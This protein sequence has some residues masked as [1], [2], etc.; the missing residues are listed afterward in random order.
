VVVS[1]RNFRSKLRAFG[2]KSIF[3]QYWCRQAKVGLSGLSAQRFEN[4]KREVRQIEA[5]KLKDPNNLLIPTKQI[6][7]VIRDFIKR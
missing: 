7:L 3:A 5:R 6:Q 2:D 4:R 1:R